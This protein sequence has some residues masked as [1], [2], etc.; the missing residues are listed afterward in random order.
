MASTLDLLRR[1]TE[2][3][4]DFVL[5]GG[6]AAAAHGSLT[7]TEDVD[8]CTHFEK[9]NL[10]R[11]LSAL[12][13][14]SPRQRMRPD[15]PPL[16]NDPSSYIGFKNLYVICEWGQIDFLGEITGVGTFQK[17]AEHA[18]WMDLGGF[19]CRVMGLED[20]I[21]AK[22]ALGRPKDL[23]VVAELELVLKRTKKT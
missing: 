6:M 19:Q 13:G 4:V 16:S 18:L 17:I 15:R 23:R 8:V 11:L 10:R 7:V 20:L 9:E 12:R 22:R 2:E 5:V 3:D 14:T 1:L 21:R